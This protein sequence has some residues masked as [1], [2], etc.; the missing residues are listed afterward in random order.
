MSRNGLILLLTLG[1]Y[2][3]QGCSAPSSHSEREHRLTTLTEWRG[4]DRD[5]PGEP[6]AA[7]ALVFAPPVTLGE[8]AIDLD[9]SVRQPSAFLGW[10]EGS[11]EH[12][13]I[14]VDD[15][16]VFG[17]A[18]GAS[19]SRGRGVGYGGWGWSDRYERRVE[20]ERVG[21]IRR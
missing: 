18:Y 9:R 12:Y 11:I 3:A 14:T 19:G 15:R 16:Q 2:I 20:S 13:R 1:V 6:V 21:A 8:P 5:F 10:D 17:N 7:S 4:G